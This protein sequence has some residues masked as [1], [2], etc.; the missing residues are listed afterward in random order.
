MDTDTEQLLNKSQSNQESNTFHSKR[1]TL[2]MIELKES[3]EFHS[4]DKS[5]NIKK[6]FIMKE[7]QFKEQLLIIM[8]LKHKSN[9]FLNKSKKLLFNINLLKE[10]GKEYN[11][12]QF[13]LKLFTTLKEKNM[14]LVKEVNIF[15]V[16]LPLLVPLA[17]LVAILPLEP[18][19]T[20]LL[21]QLDIPLVHMLFL[22]QLPIKLIQL[23]Q[24]LLL[25]MFQVDL[26][27]EVLLMEL[28]VVKLDILQS[29]H[30]VLLPIT[31]LEAELELVDMLLVDTQLEDTLL[32]DILLVG[33]LQELLDIQM[34]PLDIVLL[35]QHTPQLPI[36][37]DTQ[38]V[39]LSQEVELEMDQLLD[40]TYIIIYNTI[41]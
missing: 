25:A 29:L 35:D 33:I 16:E 22:V 12:Y 34:E 37:L 13:K 1:N 20:L 21:E 11:I 39:L 14:L 4:K 10:L 18:L 32:A 31:L 15:M 9:I 28:L 17:L 3:K 5:L 27:L 8:Q 40:V 36:L 30:Q 38:L 26:E 19:D 6:L 24:L 41:Y 23:A 7:Y 2:N